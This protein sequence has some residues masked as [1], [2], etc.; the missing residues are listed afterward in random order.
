[1]R[2]L[3]GSARSGTTWLQDTLAEANGLRTLFEPLHP[4][5]VPEASL[6]A[7]HYVRP[8]TDWPALETFLGEVFAG[9]RTRMW[10]DLRVRPDR[11]FEAPSPALVPLLAAMRVH[12]LIQRRI[13]LGQLR[14]RPILCKLIR[15]NLMLGWL[16]RRF[17]A[18]TLLLVRHP[19]GTVASQLRTDPRFWPRPEKQL[20]QYL[21]NAPLVED[22]LA[23][24]FDYLNELIDPIEIRTALWCIE[25][26]IPMGEAEDWGRGVVPH[27]RL[28][29]GDPEEWRRVTDVLGLSHLPDR[30]ALERPSAVASSP[31]K[32]Q[33]GQGPRVDRWSDELSATQKAR[34]D[35]VLERFGVREYRTCDP[36]PLS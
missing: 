8:N 33:V 3:A 23:P 13:Q 28:V 12:R 5:A 4:Q 34:I 14:D 19:A 18:R 35:D 20:R 17:S 27:E 25:N 10:T 2:L 32:E 6:F 1:V 7:F 30:E 21:A 9:R 36:L 29:Q 26:T 11:F 15:A 16:A 31:F 22:H 24:L